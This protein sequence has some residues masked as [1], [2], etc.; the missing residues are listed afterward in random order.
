[1]ETVRVR[2]L[3]LQNYNVVRQSMVDF[4]INRQLN[5]LDELWFVQHPS[6][7]TQGQ[8]GKSEHVLFPGN[9][10]VVNVERGGQVTYHGPGQIICYV[11]MDVVR[12][13]I[14][15]RG[16]VAGIEQGIMGTLNYYNVSSHLVNGAA[17]VY[18]NNEKIASI[19]L[20]IKRHCSFHGLSLNVDMDLEPFS[21][22]NP[23]GY[24]GLTMTQLSS[25]LEK[26]ITPNQVQGV[27]LSN[28]M[29]SLKY[30]HIK[31]IEGL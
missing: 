31:E 15:P 16:L 5:T 17:G 20:K 2:Y 11:M 13:G 30:Q 3:G 14:G 10:P 23:C 4:T 7:F 26:P 18:V 22:I 25:H 21:R 9:I 28:L 29:A 24:E 19:G 12:K 8:A 6:V 1:M 27:L